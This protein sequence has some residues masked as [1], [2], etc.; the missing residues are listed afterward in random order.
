MS[1]ISVAQHTDRRARA[2]VG[3]AALQ[4]GVLPW[5]LDRAGEIRILLVTSRQNGQWIVP[6]GWPVAGRAPHMSAALD[7]FEEAGVIGDTY[8]RPVADYHYLKEND[9]ASFQRCRVMLFSLNVRGTL[10][11]WPERGE[12]TRRWFALGDAA[13]M[14]EERDLVRVMATLCASPDK[15]TEFDA[16]PAMLLGPALAG[17]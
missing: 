16:E 4:Y 10:T 9:A 14:I 8:P 12:R 5:R 13:D 7:A 17:A 3:V 15:L 11:N 2:G 1:L 6:K